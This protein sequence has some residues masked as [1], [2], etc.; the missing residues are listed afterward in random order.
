MSTSLDDLDP[1][2]RWR[3]EKTLDLCLNR[4][5]KI[6]KLC[7]FRTLEEQAR[8]YRQGRTIAI[9]RAK[10]GQLDRLY[11][12]PDLAAI[13]MGVGPQHEPKKVTNSA[14]GQSLHNYRMAFDGAPEQDDKVIWDPSNPAWNIYGQAA[15]ESGLEWAGDW[16]TF[17]DFPHIQMPGI[18][19]RVLIR[20]L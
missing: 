8:L 6:R 9:I 4:G 10:A 20:K 7:T 11:M 1:E 19:W 18:T 13:L 5:V 3:V 17:K 14:P 16:K 15:R 12:R 2:F